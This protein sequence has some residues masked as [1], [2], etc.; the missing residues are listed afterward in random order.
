MG[1]TNIILIPKYYVIVL[2]PQVLF[3]ALGLGHRTDHG[4]DASMDSVGAKASS[5]VVKVLY[6]LTSCLIC[7]ESILISPE[8]PSASSE[9]SSLRSTSS[10]VYN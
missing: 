7:L 1:D 3:P 9:S 8:V 6:R 10:Y 2:I 4:P 5:E